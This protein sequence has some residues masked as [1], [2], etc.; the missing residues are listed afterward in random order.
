MGRTEGGGGGEANDLRGC[1]TRGLCCISS[2]PPKTSEESMRERERLRERRSE[3]ERER[4][5][6]S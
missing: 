1:Y 5:R 6:A 4:E 3:K 2:E